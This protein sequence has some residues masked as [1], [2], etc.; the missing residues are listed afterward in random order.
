MNY[1]IFCG[2][3]ETVRFLL[4]IKAKITCGNRPEFSLFHQVSF[5]KSAAVL[6]ME[7]SE[8]KFNGSES[9]QWGMAMNRVEKTASGV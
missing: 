3:K 6:T 5:K 1:T 2:G 9:G 4:K 8:W 7:M